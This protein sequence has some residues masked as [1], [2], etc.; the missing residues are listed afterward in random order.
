MKILHVMPSL[1]RSFG[2]PTQSWIGYARAAGTQGVE[3]AVAAPRVNSIDEQW[4]A[5]KTSGVNYAFFPATG[6]GA[7]VF[8]PALQ[9]WLAEE[10]HTYDAV[11]VH[12]LFN[13][14]SSFALRL[15]VKQDWPVVLRPFGTL[16]KYTFNHRRTWMKRKYFQYLDGPSLKRAK[17]L[18]FT[19][20]AEQEEAGWH[21]I[22]FSRRSHV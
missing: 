11:H 9:K 13:P 5:S 3:I 6:K 8:S 12:G 4:L 18:H 21:G 1:A 17:G 2:G 22:D 14:V 20:P 7:M 19:T 15:C 16:S 10:G